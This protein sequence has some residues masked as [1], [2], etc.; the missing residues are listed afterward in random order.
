MDEMESKWR[1]GRR[2]NCRRLA[3]DAENGLT[4]L[5]NYFMKEPKRT[6]YQKK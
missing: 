4:G 2:N 3:P 1:H 6:K 5:A